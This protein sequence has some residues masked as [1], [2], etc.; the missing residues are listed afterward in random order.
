MI[1]Q[2]NK[3]LK[4]FFR[5]AASDQPKGF[6]SPKY[7]QEPAVEADELE[8]VSN[9]FDFAV[10]ERS[11]VWEISGTKV[12]FGLNVMDFAFKMMDFVFKMMDFEGGFI[13]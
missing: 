3:G 1:L 10:G 6:F 13:S 7:G 8:N 12:N 9:F 5:V 11:S 4:V 2:Q